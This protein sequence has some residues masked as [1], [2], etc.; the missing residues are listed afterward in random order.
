EIKLAM[1]RS[2]EE[3]MQTF[4]QSLFKLYKEG[5]IDLEEALSKADSRGGLELK[6]RL[7]EGATVTDLPQDDPY[8]LGVSICRT[9]CAAG[10]KKSVSLATPAHRLA[11]NPSCR[12]RSN[13]AGEVGGRFFRRRERL[14]NVGVGVRRRDEQVLVRTRVEQDATR[15]HAPPPAI[16]QLLVGVAFGVAIVVDFFLRK[17]HLH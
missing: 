14:R 5:T 9:R 1:E 8:G 11:L 10:P 7:P 15:Q 13:A 12:P 17:P 6:I 2:L 3:G 16:E 4:D